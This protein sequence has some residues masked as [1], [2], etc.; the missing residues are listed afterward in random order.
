MY[1]NIRKTSRVQFVASKSFRNLKTYLT[2][3]IKTVMNNA[4]SRIEP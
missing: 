2:T 3:N 4:I 1:T